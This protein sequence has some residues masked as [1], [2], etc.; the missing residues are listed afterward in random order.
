MVLLCHHASRTITGKESGRLATLPDPLP[1][2]MHT[3]LCL[4]VLAL[5]YI[6]CLAFNIQTSILGIGSDK[7][8]TSC[9]KTVLEYAFYTHVA[10]LVLPTEDWC[11]C[12]WHTLSHTGNLFTPGITHTARSHACNHEAITVSRASLLLLAQPAS[13]ASGTV[14]TNIH[15]H[16]VLAAAWNARQH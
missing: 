10:T 16:L 4:C 13:T 2:D 1:S 12:F 5:V 15:G 3:P 9:R 11:V 6:W 14:L 7:P 8:H